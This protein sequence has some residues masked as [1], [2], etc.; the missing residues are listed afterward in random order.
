MRKIERAAWAASERLTRS[1]GSTDG[2]DRWRWAEAGGLVLRAISTAYAGAPG[3]HFLRSRAAAELSTLPSGPERRALHRLLEFT[4]EPGPGLSNALLIYAATLER[5]GRLE[6]ADAAIRLA[7]EASPDDP[8][9]S[10]HAGRIAR[11]LGDAD[12]AR[13]SYARAKALDSPCGRFG[14]LAAIGEALLSESPE[15]A[16]SRAIRD[17]FNGGDAEA[18][19]VGMEERAGVWLGLGDARAALRDLRAASIRYVDPSD[20]ARVLHRIAEVAEA[21]GDRL[22]AREALLDA[23]RVGG[24]SRREHARERL[25]ALSR[26][27]GDQLGMRRWR[28]TEHSTLSHRTG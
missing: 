26:E 16:L 17:A 22:G 23:W 20:R 12:R 28:P 13:A 21:E 14:R 18:E 25:Y 8:S 24:R 9:L 4:K 1:A 27:L 10:L 15:R 11:G 6:E 3:A 2:R 7:C 19:A 5:K